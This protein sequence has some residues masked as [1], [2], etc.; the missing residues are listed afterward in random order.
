MNRKSILKAAGILIL[1]ASAVAQ[2]P[3]P[4]APAPRYYTSAKPLD[5]TQ[6]IPPPPALNSEIVKAELAELH[7]IEKTRTPAQVAAA[8]ADDKDESIFYLRTVLGDSFGPANLP[9]TAELGEHLHSELVAENEQL[10]A[11]FSRKRPYEIDTT[12]H[13]ECGNTTQASYPSGHAIAG[14]LEAFTVAEMVPEKHDEILA[15]AD[16]FAHNRLVCG[17]HFP[18]DVEAGRRVSYALF[19][20]LMAN[21]Q[22]QSDLAGA[23]AEVRKRLGLK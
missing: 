15:R 10:K 2:M 11:E 4:S 23:Q 20:Y 1:C 14:Y 17:V 12:L 22:F 21:P 13:S 18:S 6:I 7:Q 19:A 5:L 3:A 9:L 16:E 8:Q